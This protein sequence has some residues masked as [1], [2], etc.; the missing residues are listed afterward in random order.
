ML[1]RTPLRASI[2]DQAFASCSCLTSVTIPDSVDRIGDHVF[3]RCTSF[4]SV[5]TPNRVSTIGRQAFSYC[6]SLTNVTIPNSVKSIG[7]WAFTYC[8]GLTN[9][10][11]P[12][13]VSS[14]G[15]GTFF[16]CTRL[17]SVTIPNGV[18]TIGPQAFLHCGLTNVT[19]PNSVTSI[20]DAAFSV[21]TS[22]AG[23]YF[24]GNTPVTSFSTFDGDLNSTIYYLSGTAGWG[25]TLANRPTALWSRPNP[26]ILENGPSFGVQTSGFGFVISWATNISVVVEA[27]TNLANPIW[28]PVGTNTLTDGSSYFSD[29]QWANYPTRL[30]RVRS[31]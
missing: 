19:I 29:P 20:G 21:C 16:Y 31:P 27:C 24:E 6:R 15:G 1:D 5:T 13:S 14:I 18:T 12:N 25:L 7:D 23:V 10:T 28:S 3:Y 2:G 9:A 26:L 22:L 17:T 30:Y 8:I 11:I 4:T